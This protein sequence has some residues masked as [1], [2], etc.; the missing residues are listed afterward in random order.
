METNKETSLKKKGIHFFAALSYEEMS[1]PLAAGNQGLEAATDNNH[2][3]IIMK[4][5]LDL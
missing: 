3:G 4:T 2:T 1:L 5:S